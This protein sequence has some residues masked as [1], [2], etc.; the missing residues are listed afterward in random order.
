MPAEFENCIKGGGRVRRKTLSKGRFMNICYK[1][2]ESFAG[3][4]HERQGARLERVVKE[5]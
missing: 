3:E 2:G 4:V 1:D 5:G